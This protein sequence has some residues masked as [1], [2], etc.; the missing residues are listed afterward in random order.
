[1]MVY[2][3][4]LVDG[5]LRRPLAQLFDPSLPQGAPPAPTDIAQAFI[6][7]LLRLSDCS[8][9]VFFASLTLL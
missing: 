2:P 5:R 3:F 4:S 1:M 7:G 9:V 6:L 8:V